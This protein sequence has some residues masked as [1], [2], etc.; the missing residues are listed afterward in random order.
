MA[1]FPR[2]TARAHAIGA[3]RD[4]ENEKNA[5]C[6]KRLCHP[7]PLHTH[8]PEAVPLLIGTRMV[9]AAP[10]PSSS[11]ET[12][13]ALAAGAAAC[14]GTGLLAVTV[15]LGRSR[16]IQPSSLDPAPSSLL[17]LLASSKGSIR[18]ASTGRGGAALAGRAGRMGGAAARELAPAPCCG[19]A[20]LDRAAAAVAAATAATLLR[21][22]TSTT[23][24]EIASARSSSS[25]SSPL[26]VRSNVAGADVRGGGGGGG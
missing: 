23:D 24:R 9:T 10:Q 15:A 5:D 18:R 16:G 4:C 12:A 8:L 6:P 11:L 22:D 13:A 25:L 20:A 17:L 7:R 21:N 19:T 2:D 1:V 3:L 14:R 26:W